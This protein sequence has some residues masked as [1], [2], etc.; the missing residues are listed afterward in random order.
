VIIGS[1]PDLALR[2]S[3]PPAL[4]PILASYPISNG[5]E[6]GGG[7]AQFSA[8][9][10]SPTNLDA[11]SVRIDHTLGKWSLFGRLNDAP[12]SA[13]A[14]AGAPNAPNNQQ[15]IQFDSLTAT[16]G[17]TWSPRS[18]IN[19]DLRFNYSRSKG[20]S[21]FQLTNLGSAVP[22][23]SSLVF[24]SFSNPETGA[25]AFLCCSYGS[26]IFL[27]AN[28]ANTQRQFNLVD[29][30]SYI[31]GAHQLKFGADERSLSP[32]FG[33]RT[34]DTQFLYPTPDSI[35]NNMP[36]QVYV[37]A[38]GGAAGLR[39]IANNPSAFAQDMWR[40]S[41]RL[42]FTYGLRWEYNPAPDVA[43]RE[44]PWVVDQVTN[45]ATTQ[46]ISSGAPLWH[47]TAA[48]F[49]PR[50]GVVY[51]MSDSQRW[52]TI[53]RGGAGVFYDVGFGQLGDVFAVNAQYYGQAVYTSNVSFPLTAAQQAPPPLAGTT[54][55][56]SQAAVFDPHLK[57]P[58]TVEWNVAIEQSLTP[59][60]T[61][62]ASY[63]GAAGRRLLLETYYSNP[64]PS[65]STLIVT[66]NGATSDYNA[67]QLQFRRQ[68]NRELQA[69]VSYTWSHSIDTASS[70]A[71]FLTTAPGRASS[72]FDIRHTVTG[73]ISYN[74]PAPERNG[75]AGAIFGDWSVDNMDLIRTA[76]PI[77]VIS[78]SGFFDGAYTS[79]F[80]DVLPGMPFFEIDPEVAGGKR[81]N[82]AAFTAPPA[83]QQ[84][85]APRNFLRGFGAWQTDFALRRQFPLSERLRLQFRGD[86][87]N[88]FNHPNFAGP[89]NT[90]GTPL[91]G[92][93]TSMLGQ[94]LGSGG[95]AGGFAPLYQIGGPRS[96]QL[97]VKLRF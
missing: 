91:F 46:L 26:E 59:K 33:R 58:Y 31:R 29:N 83:G 90:L 68:L 43:N 39:V 47:A 51:R 63:V 42:N 69:V 79:V 60:Q 24:P 14:Y 67:L 77:S 35:L 61:L 76:E 3:A 50:M 12:S 55:P 65:F 85:D 9:L 78:S 13:I 41:A 19:D 6:L 17:A 95:L 7:L 27:G 18:S 28:F 30:L 81:I 32:V 94:S 52:A 75:L 84:G 71:Y 44:A 54:L 2:N 11:G 80:P 73:A 92:I 74:I 34:Y 16:V 62:T 25:F 20:D 1:V 8:S 64:N 37:D 89:I 21:S 22:L 38:A 93:S 48:N 96:I 70:D 97:A 36:S 66:T 87:F 53:I 56:I 88:L 15:A 4:Q 86:F 49:A 40:A 23:P 72:D 10:S 45:I 5:P 57:L 82:P